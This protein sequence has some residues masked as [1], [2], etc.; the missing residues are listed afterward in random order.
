MVL[1]VKV[2]ELKFTSTTISKTLDLLVNLKLSPIV[3][4]FSSSVFWF[5]MVKAAIHFF[6]KPFHWNSQSLN[7]KSVKTTSYSPNDYWSVFNSDHSLTKFRH[8]AFWRWG[9]K[10]IGVKVRTK[11]DRII[12]PEIGEWEFQWNRYRYVDLVHKDNRCVA[13]QYGTCIST[14]CSE[15]PK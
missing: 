1:K 12:I 7:E 11:S 4:L 13:P 5:H 8:F 6:I 3:S 9:W 14:H 10:H 2:F 15:E